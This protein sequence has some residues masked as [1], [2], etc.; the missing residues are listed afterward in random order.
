MK[1]WG[2]VKGGRV[3]KYVGGG[4]GEVRGEGRWGEEGRGRELKCYIHTYRH[5]YRHTD[6]Q[7]P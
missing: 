5:S 4:S 1:R 2:Y 7:T 3:G 6:I